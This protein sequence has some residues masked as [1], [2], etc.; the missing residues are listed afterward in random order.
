MLIVR[1]ICL[2][3]FVKRIHFA[4]SIFF[5]IPMYHS[6]HARSRTRQMIP[7]IK[8]VEG[9]PEYLENDFYLDVNILNLIVIDDQMI[10]AGKDNRIVNLF[11]KG[12][13]HRNLN[14]IYI[15]QNLFHQGKGNRSTKKA[16]EPQKLLR[17]YFEQLIDFSNQGSLLAGRTG[18]AYCLYCTRATLIS[19]EEDNVLVC[20]KST[21][22][23]RKTHY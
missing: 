7:T 15:V 16:R 5:I 2:A 20:R 23:W 8:F 14:V 11:T 1:N 4:F 22:V 19:M 18:Q 12:S 17:F 21:L 9:I 13:H 10:E 3:C 6:L